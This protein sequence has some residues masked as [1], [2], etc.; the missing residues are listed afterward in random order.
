MTFPSTTCSNS[1]SRVDSMRSQAGRTIRVTF[2]NGSV[3]HATRFVGSLFRSTCHTRS[4]EHFQPALPKMS[5]SL[6]NLGVPRKH[7]ANEEGQRAQVQHRL[8]HGLHGRRPRLSGNDEGGPEA[9]NNR[10]PLSR[11]T[12]DPGS[13]L[14]QASSHNLRNRE[15]TLDL[16]GFD[17]LGH[18]AHRGYTLPRAGAPL[19]DRTMN[20]L[21]QPSRRPRMHESQD[22][23]AD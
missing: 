7:D 8:Q 19:V 5:T 16:P 1:A 18:K 11:T 22:R 10:D 14:A 12:T 21:G 4:G 23:A 13:T 6:T 20:P 15:R 3:G 17:T 9:A 2:R